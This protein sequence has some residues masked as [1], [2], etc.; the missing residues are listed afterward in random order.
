MTSKRVYFTICLSWI[1][2]FIIAVIPRIYANAD[3]ETKQK[4]N[5]IYE[6]IQILV[7]VILPI[8]LMCMVYLRIY[9]I[10]RKISRQTNQT[11]NQLRYNDSNSNDSPESNKKER[12]EKRNREG[13]VAVI[14]A[15]II[16]FALCWLLS[17]YNTF[18]IIF[19]VCAIVFESHLTARLFLHLNS[20]I[21]PIVYAVLKKDIRHE[22][23]RLLHGRRQRSADRFDRDNSSNLFATSTKLEL[24]G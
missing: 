24:R 18:C 9:I 1:I 12:R 13:S 23:R 15:V 21:N 10:A 8:L 4:A 16:L 5:R 17:V 14:G 7:F 3:P 6:P 20:S 22:L 11:N 2:P 19:G